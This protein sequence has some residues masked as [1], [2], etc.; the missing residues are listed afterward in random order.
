MRDKSIF[1]LCRNANYHSEKFCE[2]KRQILL[3]ARTFSLVSPSE[4]WIIFYSHL[5]VTRNLINQ[6]DNLGIINVF[7]F[8]LNLKK[9]KNLKKF[10]VAPITSPLQPTR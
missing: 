3:S 4:I 6:S 8:F 7:F 2:S 5:I 9:F 10:L 1:I